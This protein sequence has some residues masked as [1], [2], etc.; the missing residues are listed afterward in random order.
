MPAR[1]RP[2]DR[3]RG[4]HVH[5]PDPPHLYRLRA[6]AQDIG[7]SPRTVWNAIKAGELPAFRWDGSRVVLLRPEAVRAWADARLRPYRNGNGGAA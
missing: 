3:D 2:Y 4:A 5:V 1:P 7:F 6:A